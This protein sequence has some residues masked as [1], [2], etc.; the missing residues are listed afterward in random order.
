M[1]DT[2]R[3]AFVVK[4][5]HSS[6]FTQ[7][8]KIILKK[9]EIQKI[10]LYYYLYILLVSPTYTQDIISSMFHLINTVHTFILNY[11]TRNSI[12][13]FIVQF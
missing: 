13:F 1:V 9:N 12:E 4:P 5:I 10:N 7:N 3:N 2:N 8:L 6:Y 11:T